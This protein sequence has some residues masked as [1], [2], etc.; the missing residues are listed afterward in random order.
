M[1]RLLV[2]VVFGVVGVVLIGFVEGADD[3]VG[4]QL[5]NAL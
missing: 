5:G 2:V 3:A 1:W 4:A